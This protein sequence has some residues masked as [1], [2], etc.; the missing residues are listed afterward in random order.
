MDS[1]NKHV[2]C[3]SFP[4]DESHENTKSSSSA[5]QKHIVVMYVRIGGGDYED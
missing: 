2:D 3:G 1:S 4:F 5:G